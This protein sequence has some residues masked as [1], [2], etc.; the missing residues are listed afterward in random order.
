MKKIIFLIVL[1][2]FTSVF[3]QNDLTGMKFCLDPGHG[4]YPNDKPY[5]TRINLR[6]ANFLK[7]Y[8]ESYNAWVI[9]TR[10][11]SAVYV[12]LSDREYIANSNNVDFFL[13]IH[14]NAFQG[15]ANYTLMLY[16]QK[17]NNQPEW[18]GQS[19][20]MCNIMANYLYQYLY[21]TDKYVRGDLSFLGFNLGVL[22]DLLMPGV[23]S[24]ASF[25][26]FPP[27]VHRLN[28]LGYLKLE[29]FALVHSFLD[30]YSIP[31]NP[32][33]F[34]EGVVQDLYGEKFTDITVKLSNGIDEMIYV[35]DSQNIG[36]T[37]QDRAWGGFPQIYDVRNG[38]YFFENFPLGQ[39]KLIFEGQ[40]LVTDTVDIM[41]IARTSTRINPIEMVED[42]P[43]TIIATTPIDGDSNFSA[44]D[45]ISIKFSRPMNKATVESAFQ[46]LPELDGYFSWQDRN[47][48]VKFNPNTRFEFDQSY[49]LQISGEAMDNW[50][51][52]LDGN[53]DG[54]AGDAFS[55][56]FQT[57]P[58][59]TSIPMVVDF[60]PVNNATGI[61]INDIFRAEFN[62][63]LDPAS[64]S[65][66]RVLLMSDNYRR[67]SVLTDYTEWNN[68]GII[69]I[70]PTEL[71][72][73]NMQYN[74]TI[75]NSVMDLQG[76]QMDAHFQWT[77]KTQQPTLT[78]FTIEDFETGAVAGLTPLLWKLIP[79]SEKDSLKLSTARFAHGNQ[80]LS[81][82]YDLS[83]SDSLALL[84]DHASDSTWL[85]PDATIAVNIWGDHSGNQMR[86]VFE[87][88]DGFEASL[89]ITI[90]WSGWK[91]IRFDLV[92]DPVIPWGTT[93]PGNGNL[94]SAMHIAGFSLKA[95]SS[96]SSQIYLDD[97]EQIFVPS[98][99][100]ISPYAFDGNQPKA[101]EL[102]PNYPNPFNPQ[103]NIPYDVPAKKATYVQL[104][105]Y[106]I[107]GREI[108]L[109]VDRVQQAGHYEVQW[110][111]KDKT[112]N[113]VASGIYFYQ[114]RIKGSVITNKM[115]LIR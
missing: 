106:D 47:R 14:H 5:E 10:Q 63:I 101:F 76:N 114:L 49:M 4:D 21:T 2:S 78:V 86:F 9:T 36:I 29:A 57:A 111:G 81:I 53:G 74:L 75:A 73:P 40:G 46:L 15:N 43:P 32:D 91:K 1:L 102:Y 104:K 100:S 82:S 31:K 72:R 64:I 52:H 27:E 70:L 25:W 11:D 95:N 18:P 56:I 71:M 41:V 89:P 88:P 65:G 96:G 105:I 94:D 109:L 20:V 80:S 45:K 28:S 35:T 55:M 16:E 58:M 90:D 83:I 99:T 44:F 24:E 48:E 62:K 22:N 26:D 107:T 7:D 50:N 77:F 61:F 30:Y 3:A 59:D 23:L 68:Q 6:V 84:V 38:M 12:S 97:I 60:Y 108:R 79:Q 69:S 103:T 34:V 93:D 67:I 85:K 112:G 8:L 51:Y 66:A 37:N 13:S 33:A 17:S 19:D 54:I 39:A 113:E 92:N 42:I 98:P 110:D 87:D 115:A